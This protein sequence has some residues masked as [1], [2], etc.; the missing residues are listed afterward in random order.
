M[1]TLEQEKQ[2]LGRRLHGAMSIELSTIPTYMTAL[3]S[4]KPGRNRVAANI[5]RSV[6]MEEMLHLS[7]A[8]N[9]L[10][11]IGGKTEF[12]ADNIPNYPVLLK[13]DGIGFKDREFEVDLGPFSPRN[14]EIFTQIELPEGWRDDRNQVKEKAELTVP[15]YTIGEFYEKILHRLGHLCEAYGE[16]AVFSGDP[17]LQLNVNH[18]WAGGGRPVVISDLVSA[19]KA[20]DVIVTQ[21]EGTPGS[22]FDGDHDQ[23]GQPE[24]V[25]HFFRFREIQFG[26][27]YKPS[28]NPRLPPTGEQFE[29][30]YG[31]VYPIKTNAKAADYAGDPAMSQRNAE[32]NRLYTLMLCQ[33]AEALNGAPGAMYTAI[34][35][36][37][38]DMT[39]IA[40]QMVA[41]PIADDPE[42][43]H[44]A[45]SFEWVP[46]FA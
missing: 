15:G 43:R 28:D 17:T 46:P 41:T 42:K 3:I 36:S 4:I 31:A 27:R 25:A 29:V 2:E 40:L 45:P 37:M 18:Y 26:R 20:I 7:L 19:K 34:L 44:G 11:A 21:G 22:V 14:V 39:A 35:N 13:F 32:F 9:L 10:S 24:D 1:K 33:I 30:D 6:M 5:I 38:H 8:G 12:T 16:K 23:F